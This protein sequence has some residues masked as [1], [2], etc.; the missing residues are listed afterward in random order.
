LKEHPELVDKISQQVKEMLGSPG[1]KLGM[2]A[3]G[4]EKEIE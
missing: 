4:D 3:T 1:T 2:A